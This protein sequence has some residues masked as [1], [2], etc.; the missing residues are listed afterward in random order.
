MIPV[1]CW[2]LYWNIFWNYCLSACCWA[3]CIIASRIPWKIWS[4]SFPK[5][6]RRSSLYYSSVWFSITSAKGT[7]P[8]W[9]CI[10]HTRNIPA[11]RD[12]VMLSTALSIRQPLWAAVPASQESITWTKPVSRFPMP[13]ACTFSNILSTRSL[14]QSIVCYCFWQ[15]MDLFMLHLPIIR[16]IS[17]W[18][19]QESVWLQEFC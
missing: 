16:V 8:G 5:S 11:W 9:L 3:F 1:K 19:L 6:P 13:P 7:S 18:D 14:W 4:Q 12:S 15:P 2:A 10:K 17:C